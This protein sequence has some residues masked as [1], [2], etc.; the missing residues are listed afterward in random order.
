M[1]LRPANCYLKPK[2]SMLPSEGE[3]AMGKIALV[4]IIIAVVLLVLAAQ[5]HI[6]N[7]RLRNNRRNPDDH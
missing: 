2:A 3:T 4:G 5:R 1:T 6:A 7:K